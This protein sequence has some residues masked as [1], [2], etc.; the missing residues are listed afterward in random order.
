MPSSTRGPPPTRAAA[1]SEGIPR[2]IESNPISHGGGRSRPCPPDLT[3]PD[4]GHAVER[5]RKKD[6]RSLKVPREKSFERR[7]TAFPTLRHFA[8]R[9]IG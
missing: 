5:R 3:W 2:T 8:P 1:S 7:K 4:G 9:V 6:E